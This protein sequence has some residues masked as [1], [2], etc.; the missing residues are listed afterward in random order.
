M[1]NPSEAE[2]ALALTD[3]GGAHHDYEQVSLRGIRDERWSGCYA[4]YALGRLGHFLAPS[5]FSRWLEEAPS[6]E[7]WPT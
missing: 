2:L 5:T 3:A 1:S 7:S 6:G 4:A